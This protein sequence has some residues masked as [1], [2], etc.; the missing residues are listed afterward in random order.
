MARFECGTVLLVDRLSDA[1]ARLYQR[2]LR[3]HVCHVLAEVPAFLKLLEQERH[4]GHHLAGYFAYE[5]GFAFEDKLKARYHGC[6][7]TPLAWFGVYEAPQ[8]LSNSEERAWLRTAAEEEAAP[9][10]HVGALDMSRE[11][12]ADAF[13]R[14]QQHL[15][16]GDIYQINL[17]MRAELELHGSLPGLFDHLLFQQPVGYAALIHLG[18]QQVASI[19]PEL[20][21]QRRG[22]QLTTRP[23]KGTAKRGRTTQE[24]AE[25]KAW[26]RADEKSRAENTMILD[27]MRNDLSRIVESGSVQ[28]PAHCE[29]EQYRSLFQMTSTT[30]GHLVEGAE[31]PEIMAEL[32][33]CGSI[34]GAPKLWAMEIIDELEQS[35]RGIYTGSIGYI[36]PNGDFTF[37]VAIRTLVTDGAGKA[38]MG[39]GSGVVYDSGASPEYD[40]CL[41]KLDF[42]RNSEPAF[43]LFETLAWTPEDGYLLLERHLRRMADSADYFGFKWSADLALCV[44]HRRAERFDGPMRV[45]LDLAEDGH[46]ELTTQEMPTASDSEWQVCLADEP[47]NSQD[48]FLFHKTSRRQFY[49]DTR[50]RLAQEQNCQEVLFYNEHGYLTE[51]SFTNVFLRFGERLL[52]PAL[53]HG[54]LP[55]VLRD[56]MLAHG[57]AEEADLKRED[58]SKADAVYLGNSLRGLMPARVKF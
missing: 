22:Q 28:V 46:F 49:D 18:E 34:T 19:S 1:P 50:A 56:G 23:M 6:G 33:P 29:V 21:L 39:T 57:Y 41:L 11:A 51:G 31:L 30:Q 5:F 2:P 27:L 25:I 13:E 24:D 17:T 10:V 3:T 9:H 40:E 14:T 58:L 53:T 43:T 12:Y 48:R 42:L 4:A 32:F 16:Q 26:L 20:F 52:T 38:Q 35:P 36:E 45:R 37:N 7:D 8:F 44:L 55:G 47:V 15:A 54:L